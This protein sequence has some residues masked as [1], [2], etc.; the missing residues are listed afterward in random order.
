MPSFRGSS[1]YNIERTRET[2][3]KQERE[4]ESE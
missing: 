3:R 2:E 4:R 1:M